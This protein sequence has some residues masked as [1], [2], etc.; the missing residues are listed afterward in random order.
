M[1]VNRGL[2]PAA[3]RHG[4]RWLPPY[5]ADNGLSISLPGWIP[6][7][8]AL[9]R[10]TSAEGVSACWTRA[11]PV[12][13]GSAGSRP[14]GTFSHARLRGLR[15]SLYE[16]RAVPNLPPHLF[17]RG[18]PLARRTNERWGSFSSSN[19]AVFPARMFGGPPSSLP[20]LRGRGQPGP[21][22]RVF[23]CSSPLHGTRFEVGV[24]SRR[25]RSAGGRRPA[26][27]PV[28]ASRQHGYKL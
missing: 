2:L 17:Y 28:P 15:G 16:A 9:G 8:A 26:R 27:P 20:L 19:P 11:G 14:R 24:R 6:A 4:R 3:R 23:R 22:C 13:S 10:R 21:R 5:L 25:S 7:A 18:P 1:I 12:E